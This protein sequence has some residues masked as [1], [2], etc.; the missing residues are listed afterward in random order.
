MLEKRNI[1]FMWPNGYSSMTSVISL[2]NR[3]RI[4]IY[5]NN[6]IGIVSLPIA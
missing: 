4:E 6:Y 2:L 3:V 1:N 5:L